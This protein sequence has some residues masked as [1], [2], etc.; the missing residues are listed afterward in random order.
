MRATVALTRACTT[1]SVS[2]SSSKMTTSLTLRTPRLR[3][4]PRADD[5]A[6]DDGRTRDG[7]EHAHLAALD[8]LGDFDFA[9]A[10]EQGNGAHFAQVHADGVVGLF[11]R[12]GREV[13]L[14]VFAFFELEILVAG[15]LG[16]VEQVDALGAD[17]G[18]QIV[19][20][21]GAR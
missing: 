10:G 8:A 21:V 6:D 16:R 7:L 18:D 4:S 19:E 1:S 15:E 2:S 17:G 9:L 11:Q 5:F 14:D 20:V 13:E 12:A 3:S